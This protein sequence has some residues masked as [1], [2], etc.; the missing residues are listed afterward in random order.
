MFLMFECQ[1]L[2]LFSNTRALMH[3]TEKMKVI[4]PSTLSLYEKKYWGPDSKVFKRDHLW[5]MQ[6]WN[7]LHL[8]NS[9]WKHHS[10]WFQIKNRP[11]AYIYWP[12][13]KKGKPMRKWRQE[14]KIC[15]IM[16]TK[17]ENQWEHEKQRENLWEHEKKE[18][19]WE[20]ENKKG[21]LWEHEWRLNPAERCPACTNIHHCPP[22]WVFFAE[23]IH[24]LSYIHYI[25]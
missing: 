2:C 11:H 15:E 6:N 19:L 20:N 21:N 24:I 16:K 22:A 3:S 1:N 9:K 10:W 12:L 17:R 23:Y 14:D 8:I 18:N 7:K 25:S 4:H 5:W 13:K